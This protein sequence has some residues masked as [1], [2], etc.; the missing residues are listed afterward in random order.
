MKIKTIFEIFKKEIRDIL[1][2][3]KT[4]RMMVLVPLLLF[5]ILIMFMS[6]IFEEIDN[7]SID[8]YNHIGIN[9]EVDSIM[10]S[11]IKE[12]DIDITN[13]QDN[14][15]IASWTQLVE[16]GKADEDSGIN[17]NLNLP[18]NTKKFI[19]SFLQRAKQ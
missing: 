9:F 17:N 14:K 11:I 2:D 7:Q 5:P 16:E 19:R 8:N 3:K 1:R 12:L 10:D 13:D 6:Y 15:L 4:L 18:E